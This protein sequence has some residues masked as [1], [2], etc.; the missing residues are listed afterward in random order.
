[1]IGYTSLQGA[2]VDI[3]LLLPVL[4]TNA[5]LLELHSIGYVALKFIGHGC[6]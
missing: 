4:T 3:G 2:G 5:L 6:D 1:M